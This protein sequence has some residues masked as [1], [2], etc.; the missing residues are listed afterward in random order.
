MCDHSTVTATDDIYLYFQEEYG[1]FGYAKVSKRVEY[2][3]NNMNV[4]LKL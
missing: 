2:S 3:L 4:L 1:Y